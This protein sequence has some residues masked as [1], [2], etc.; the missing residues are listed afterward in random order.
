MGPRR[1]RA[2]LPAAAAAA[3]GAFGLWHPGTHIPAVGASGAVAGCMGAFLIAYAGVRIRFAYFWSLGWRQLGTFEARAL[4]ALPLWFARRRFLSYFE[5]GRH[6]GRRALG[7]RGRLRLRR[8]RGRG[9]QVRRRRGQAPDARTTRWTRSG[10]AR[11]PSSSRACLRARR[12]Q[13]RRRSAAS[14]GAG[15]RAEPPD[16]ARARARLRDRAAQARDRAFARRGRRAR[17]ARA[18]GAA[19]T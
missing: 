16:G 10:A 4:Y 3:A 2:V 6:G 1:V 18:T 15:A 8:R 11:T 17:H 14:A 13:G 7:A 5:A 9:A 19:T 12:A